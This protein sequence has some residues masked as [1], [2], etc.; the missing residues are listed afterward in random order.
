MGLM[1]GFS[2]PS[3]APEFKPVLFPI[4]RDKMNAMPWKRALKEGFSRQFSRQVRLVL[5]AFIAGLSV[6]VLLI[7]SLLTSP[8]AAAGPRATSLSELEKLGK[9][10]FFD[11][12]LS[13]NKNMSCAT[14]HSAQSGGT[15]A[16]D[17]SNR[18]RGLHPGSL[19]QA[20]DKAPSST[21]TF[22]FRNIQTNAYA[23]YS[24][25]L[26]RELNPDGSIT[27]IG[28]NFWDGRATGFITGRPTQ[29]QAMAPFLGSLEMALPEPACV[30]NRVVSNDFQ[31]RHT[32]SY[33]S[34]FGTKVDQVNW[35]SNITQL[36][37]K[38]DQ[39]VDLSSVSDDTTVARAYS[40]I[41]N[42][43]WAYQRSADIV[44]FSSKFD[45]V[46]EGKAQLSTSEQRGL[47]LFNGKAKCSGCHVTATTKGRAKALFTDYSYDNLGVPRNP[48][49]PVYRFAMIN[50]DGAN[51]IDQGLGAI[52]RHDDKLR[53]QADVNIG[54]FKVPT[55]RNVDRKP[56]PDFVR[57]YM[58]NG[59]F[60]SLEQ[61]VDFYNSRDV[62][63]RCKD[64]FTD[65]DTAER[66]GCWP[67]PEVSQNLNKTELGN[68]GLNNQDQA[69]LV[70]FLKT[71]SDVQTR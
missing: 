40:N 70:A 52:L 35:P 26:H 18:S 43:L 23:V 61:V 2:S 48:Q 6:T 17:A 30:V 47:D 64:R 29:E 32:L 54:K 36:C 9:E 33:Q 69:D 53:S 38:A 45:N 24:P 1:G 39:I 25:P 5:L 51:W 62:K 31:Q 37:S 55:L 42:A 27:M 11:T 65:I 21:N 15:A 14:C 12:T 44:P 8:P 67:E 60:R 28:G 49:N 56:N 13:V 20:D 7:S 46:T 68:L 58:H 63:P 22:A 59:Y 19:F 4:L 10:I 66:L 41:A 50:P 34:V 57:A 71:L 3:P 16:S